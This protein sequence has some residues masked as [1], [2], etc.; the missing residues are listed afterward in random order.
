MAR[1]VKSPIDMMKLIVWAKL[2][3]WASHFLIIPNILKLGNC[4]RGWKW[5]NYYSLVRKYTWNF[6]GNG[7]SF[8]KVKPPHCRPLVSTTNA[9]GGAPKYYEVWGWGPILDSF[10]NF[11]PIF[12]PQ[13]FLP[14]FSSERILVNMLQQ[15]KA[16]YQLHLLTM[17]NTWQ[18]YLIYGGSR[19]LFQSPINDPFDAIFD[20]WRLVDSEGKGN[21]PK[22]SAKRRHVR[23]SSILSGAL[24]KFIENI[25]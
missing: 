3:K 23:L 13:V 11:R 6:T 24:L 21:L 1:S 18:I 5:H 25:N 17:V 8:A 20:I 22:P 14:C 19:E 9:T 7:M 12:P 4:F 10:G 15:E 16:R 2:Y